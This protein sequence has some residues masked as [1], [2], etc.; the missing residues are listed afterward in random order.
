MGIDP[1]Q[2]GVRVDRHGARDSAKGNRVVSSKGQSKRALLQVRGNRASDGL[3]DGRDKAGVEELANGWV[4]GGLHHAVV[5]VAVKLDLPVE[6]LE[7]VKETKLDDLEGTL[8]N[9]S[10]GLFI[11]CVNERLNVLLI[12][13]S[14]YMNNEKSN[15]RDNSRNRR[16]KGQFQ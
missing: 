3:G 11:G 15:K 16:R 5:A 8:I 10:S 14:I 7:L 12:S 6:L 13:R 9:T 2:T 4:R 1:D